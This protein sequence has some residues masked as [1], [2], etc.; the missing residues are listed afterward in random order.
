MS[1][2][3]YY[4]SHDSN[5]RND[6][7]LLKIRMKHGMEGY[8]IYFA[9]VEMLREQQDYILTLPDIPCIAYDL[10]VEIGLIEEIVFN[11]DLFEVDDDKFYSRSLKRRMEKLD[12][13]KKV[14]AEAGRKG[15]KTTAKVKQKD[16]NATAVK[17]SKVKENKVNKVKDIN[18]RYDDFEVDVKNYQSLFDKE[19]IVEFIS[20]WTEPNKS[21]T[22]MKFE[23]Q[24]TWDTKR[25]IGR[26]VDNDFSSNKS[27]GMGKFKKDATGN[28]WL[29]YCSKCNISDFYDDTGIKQDSRCCQSKLMPEK[30][31]SD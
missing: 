9:I 15:G 22:K 18:K 6:Q 19:S 8:G 31:K 3:A 2:D 10:R 25:R 29:G 26:W 27:N 4:F 24:P 28:S 7:R 5:A 17:K 12:E 20:Y 23:M 13:K 14:R 1:K 11:Y 30:K 21:N 16:S